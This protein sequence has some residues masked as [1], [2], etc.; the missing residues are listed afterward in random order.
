MNPHKPY[1]IA[2]IS[3]NAVNRRKRLSEIFLKSIKSISKI[4]YLFLNIKRPS[5]YRNL[6][7]AKTSSL[8]HDAIINY[9]LSD[10]DRGFINKYIN[11]VVLPYILQYLCP[12]FVITFGKKAIADLLAS[13]RNVSKL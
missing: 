9:S 8:N 2:C 7:H 6:L 4:F 10:C 12:Y 1:N 3:K 13:K 11:K 5:S